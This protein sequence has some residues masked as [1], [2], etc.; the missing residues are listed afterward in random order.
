MSTSTTKLNEHYN[1]RVIVWKKEVF[2]FV[3]IK[4]IRKSHSYRL[5]VVIQIL[6][7][8]GI[9]LCL[10]RKKTYPFVKVESFNEKHILSKELWF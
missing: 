3:C 1:M 4:Q 9:E 10:L 6:P 2:F 5:F 7:S 8:F